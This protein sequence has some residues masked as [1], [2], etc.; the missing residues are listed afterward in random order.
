V[1]VANTDNICIFG[2]TENVYGIH[3]DGARMYDKLWTPN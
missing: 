2:N 3:Y 1:C